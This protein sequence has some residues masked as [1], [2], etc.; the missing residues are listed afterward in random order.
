LDFDSGQGM[1][2]I[3]G[4]FTQAQVRATFYPKFE[5]EK[6]DQEVSYRRT[7]GIIG[8][9]LSR[10]NL[11]FCSLFWFHKLRLLAD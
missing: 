5:N 1:H 3:R 11:G 6:S 2:E 7:I 4:A 9:I 10:I 8:F